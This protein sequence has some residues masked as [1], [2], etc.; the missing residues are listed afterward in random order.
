MGAIEDVDTAIETSDVVMLL[1][2]QHERHEGEKETS[3]EEYHQ[4]F[5]LTIER[6]KRMKQE[7]LLCIL[8][9]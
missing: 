3:S 8:L 1:R 9:Q 2:I 5:G 7:V 6:E 4:A